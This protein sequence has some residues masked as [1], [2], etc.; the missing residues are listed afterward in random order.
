MFWGNR[1]LNFSLAT[2]EINK[3]DS[4]LCGQGGEQKVREKPGWSGF[5]SLD[6]K[7][8]IK[9]KHESTREPLQSMSL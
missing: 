6:L 3:R 2:C 4:D 1:F 8:G 7:H 9:L 5:S